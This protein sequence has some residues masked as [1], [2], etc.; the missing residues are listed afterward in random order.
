MVPICPTLRSMNFALHKTRPFFSEI[1]SLGVG[2]FRSRSNPDD[3]FIR[4]SLDQLEQAACS[5]TA[6]NCSVG[7]DI[8]DC[9]K[10]RALSMKIHLER[11]FQRGEHPLQE[12]LSHNRSDASEVELPLDALDDCRYNSLQLLLLLD[13]LSL[14]DTGEF[15]NSYTPSTITAFS[16]T[17]SFN[18]TYSIFMPFTK[19]R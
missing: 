11:D 9:L 13:I 19:V 1:V 3:R 4:F 17:L 10:V 5:Q 12:Y 16:T 8:V 18:L 15:V 2:E 14:R 6:S 7:F